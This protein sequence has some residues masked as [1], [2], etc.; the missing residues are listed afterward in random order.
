MI[1][2]LTQRNIVARIAF[3]DEEITHFDTYQQ[4][5][6]LLTF[7]ISNSHALRL[8]TLTFNAGLHENNSESQL[9][10][11]S[12]E[13]TKEVKISGFNAAHMLLDRSGKFLCLVDP[14]GA[15]KIYLAGTFRCVRDFK[16]GF[17]PTSVRLRKNL[18][19]CLTKDRVL[20]AYDVV[21]GKRFKQADLRKYRNVDTAFGE[22]V[23][24]DDKMR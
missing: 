8:H 9:E 10:L 24:L 7:S 16:F 13:M 22:F 4:A 5:H 12:S 15:M 3:E 20:G 18:I 6:E 11:I 1:Y 17:G 14:R 19:F 23:V 2:H 21:Q